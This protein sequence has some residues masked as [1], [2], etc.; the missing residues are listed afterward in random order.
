MLTCGAGQPWPSRAALSHLKKPVGT[1]DTTPEAGASHA[2]VSW[3]G[4]TPT[5]LDILLDRSPCLYDYGICSSRF[6][7]REAELEA[8]ISESA[9]ALAAMQRALDERARRAAAA[10]ERLTVLE[11][12][13]AALS[14]S[15]SALQEQAAHR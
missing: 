4:N 3:V 9:A 12:E 2:Q 1:F 6:V 13:R 14:E 15:L 5:V 11:L 7:T 8:N 10:E